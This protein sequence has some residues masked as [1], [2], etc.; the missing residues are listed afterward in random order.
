MLGHTYIE[1]YNYD[2]YLTVEER[3]CNTQHL[4]IQENRI[5]LRI[6]DRNAKQQERMAETRIVGN[7]PGLGLH[8]QPNATQGQQR[9]TNQAA[10]A[11]NSQSQMNIIV[12]KT[13]SQALITDHPRMWTAI[14]IFSLFSII[15]ILAY[16]ADTK[17]CEQTRRTYALDKRPEIGTDWPGE[18]PQ[19]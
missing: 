13:W 1:I 16:V 2:C 6:H 3:Y 10:P 17:T 11:N 19:L 14:L 8:R 7:Q 9:P 5:T 15:G 12:T 18:V 4:A